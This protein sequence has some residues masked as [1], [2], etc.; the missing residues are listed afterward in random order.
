VRRRTLAS[1]ELARLAQRGL[2]EARIV[3]IDAAADFRS[4]K[5]Q[6]MAMVD[7]SSRPTP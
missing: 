5:H 2:R 4:N 1:V 3:E 7:S 6:A